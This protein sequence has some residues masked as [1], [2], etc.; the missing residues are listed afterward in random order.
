MISVESIVAPPSFDGSEGL[1]ALIVRG[2][3]DQVGTQFVT[4]TSHELQVGVIKKAA[5]DEITPHVHLVHHRL[6][7]ATSEVLV[8][9]KGAVLVNFYTSARELVGTRLLRGGDVLVS[10]GGGHG[11]QFTE[12]TEMLEVKT[13]PYFGRSSDKVQF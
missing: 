1:L 4:A 6:V 3:P 8:I 10:L 13:G 7:K 12:E 5:G 2:S 9:R 11:F